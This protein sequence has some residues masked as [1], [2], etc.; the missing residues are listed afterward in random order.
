MRIYTINMAVNQK[1]CH[2]RYTQHSRPR[3]IAVM[4]YLDYHTR[5]DYKHTFNLCK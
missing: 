2:E 1:N 5:L 4:I 3:P